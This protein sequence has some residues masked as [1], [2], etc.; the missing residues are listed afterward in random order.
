MIVRNSGSVLRECLEHSKTWIDRWTILD[1]GSTDGTPDL[2]LEVLKDVPGRLE[3]AEFEDF[4]TARNHALS[5]VSG[6]SD[7]LAMLDDSYVLCGGENLASYLQGCSPPQPDA[8]LLQIGTLSDGT[9]RNPIFSHRIMRRD[10]QLKYRYRVHEV[11]DVSGSGVR[12]VTLADDSG[13]FVN[14]LSGFEHEQRS[15]VRYAQDTVDLLLDHAAEPENPRPLYYLASTYRILEKFDD[16]LYSYKKLSE[17]PRLHD[18]YKFSAGYDACCIRYYTTDDVDAFRCA[19]EA[20][21]RE[22][23]ERA[24]PGYKLAVLGRGTTWMTTDQLLRRLRTLSLLEAPERCSTHIDLDIYDYFIPFLLV[25]TLLSQGYI[26]EAVPILKRLLSL[27]PR[28]QPLL[29]IKYSICDDTTVSS[30]DLN[31]GSE[32]GTLVFYLS[33][34]DA[35]VGVWDPRGDVNVS[36]TEVGC[37][38]LAREFSKR[39]FRVLVFA[40]FSDTVNDYQG[41]VDGVE[42]LDASLFTQF[43]MKYVVDVLVVVRI[44][45]HLV[46][47]TN[48]RSVFLW[49]HDTLPYLNARSRCIQYHKEKF[50]GIIAVSEWQRQNTYRKLNVPLSSIITSRNAISI[51]RFTES[52]VA[53]VPY[54]FI[55]TSSPD[56]G[57][58]VLLAMMPG[59]KQKYPQT[60]L[61][62][63][64]NASLLTAAQKSALRALSDYAT[65]SPRVD[66]AQLALELLA[67]DVFLYPCTFAETYCIAAVEAMAARC[68]VAT[69]DIGG[70]GDVARNRSVMCPHPVEQHKETLLERLDYVMQRPSLKSAL[71]DKAFAWASQQT[72]DRLCDSWINTIF[73]G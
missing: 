63:F 5:L 43:V 54:R 22:F 12:T 62:V 7:Y 66:Q 69:V 27:Y 53:K 13:I 41:T 36:G 72:Y 49:I 15:A 64:V 46:Y 4:S 39:G 70:L 48:I 29:N 56:R 8:I 30:I 38:N 50:K 16:A 42:F 9:L 11:L 6:E 61:K 35:S 25:D 68:L 51:D 59:L 65:V 23:P 31:P 18:D 58:D 33:S 37:L 40:T 57:L 67:A 34:E 52:K 45:Q 2:I 55:Y 10:A 20:L 47:Y 73:S 28:D 71:V 19:L 44:V 60:T 3:H 21:E 26:S 24:E 14:D 32:C 1:T 17:I